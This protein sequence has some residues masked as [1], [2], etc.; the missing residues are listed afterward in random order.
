M[1]I[2]LCLYGLLIEYNEFCICWST[3]VGCECCGAHI[4]VCVQMCLHTSILPLKHS[5]TSWCLKVQENKEGGGTLGPCFPVLYY[6]HWIFG[7]FGGR[8]K[9]VLF[10][11]KAAI[12]GQVD[13]TFE[14]R[15]NHNTTCVVLVLFHF[16]PL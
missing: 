11:I 9:S 14:W 4:Y 3:T 16:W 8:E 13:L 10:E 1:S 15:D 12:M 2:H 5:S 7:I 6:G